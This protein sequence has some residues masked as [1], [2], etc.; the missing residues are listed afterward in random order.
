VITL[1]KCRSTT[2]KSSAATLNTSIL[3]PALTNVITRR[4]KSL[5][6]VMAITADMSIMD[7]TVV[8]TMG[9]MMVTVITI[10]MDMTNT[11]SACIKTDATSHT[12]QLDTMA[13]TRVRITAQTGDIIIMVTITVQVTTILMDMTVMVNA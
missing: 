5:A 10:L 13:G 4:R 1:T 8:T 12:I 3:D 9:Q 7:L 2:K 11:A 6:E